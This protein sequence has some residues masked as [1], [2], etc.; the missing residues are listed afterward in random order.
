MK[1]NIPPPAERKRMFEELVKDAHTQSFIIEDGRRIY[2]WSRG[3][4]DNGNPIH[5][6]TYWDEEKQDS[7]WAY[8]SDSVYQEWLRYAGL[9]ELPPN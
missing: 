4:D 8:I 5:M 7:M 1:Q 2:P 3:R 9:A 6:V